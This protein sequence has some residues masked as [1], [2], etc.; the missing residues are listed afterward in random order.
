MGWENLLLRGGIWLADQA[1]GYV[2]R[3][4]FPNLAKKTEIYEKRHERK[5]EQIEKAS[6][7][8]KDEEYLKALKKFKENK[9]PEEYNIVKGLYDEYLAEK[10]SENEESP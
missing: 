7:R 3:E 4:K 9:M 10:N 5:Y 6:R 1:L 8:W 2:I